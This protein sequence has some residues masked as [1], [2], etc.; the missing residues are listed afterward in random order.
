MR[1]TRGLRRGQFELRYRVGEGRAREVNQRVSVR[2]EPGLREADVGVN[3]EERVHDGRV[4]H[5]AATADDDLQCLALGEGAPVRA[6][7]GQRVVAVHDAHDAG[8]DRNRLAG[9]AVRVARTVP[10]LVVVADNRR[11]GVREINLRE[12]ARADGRVQLHALVFGRGQ[13]AGLVQDELWNRELPHVVKKRSRL[14]RLHQR[15]VGDAQPF[16]KGHGV[17]LHPADVAVG[18]LILRVDG[19]R[20]RLDGRQVEPVQLPEVLVRVLHAGCRRAEGQVRDEQQRP[21]HG[22]SRE[23]F[24]TFEEPEVLHVPHGKLDRQHQPQGRRRHRVQSR[25]QEVAAPQA[26]RRRT[27]VERHGKSGEP[28][29]DEE[30]ARTHRQRGEQQRGK[31]RGAARQRHRLDRQKPEEQG[32]RDGD[33][34]GRLCQVEAVPPRLLVTPSP[35]DQQAVDGQGHHARR[36]AEQEHLRE[37]ERFGDIEACQD[38]GDL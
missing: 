19:H 10:V 38:A 29:V 31:P 30:V 27:R 13:L 7:G 36:E 23:V 37:H 32:A 9:E 24:G 16:G 8:A 34:D 25:P 33:R 4:V 17:G 15:L 3:G 22:K 11:D 35:G 12:D 2:L 20:Q 6:V 1:G 26:V 5:G 14:D 28:A 21:D 18:D